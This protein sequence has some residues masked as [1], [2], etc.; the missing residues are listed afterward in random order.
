MNQDAEE[1]GHI[2][3]IRHLFLVL[4]A[5]LK[6]DFVCSSGNGSSGIDLFL[7]STRTAIRGIGAS[8]RKFSY[9]VFDGVTKKIAIDGQVAYC[10]GRTSE[11][12]IEC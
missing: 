6:S 10:I 7:T 4:G 3:Q 5:V 9:G 8:C 11:F 2:V 12:A 1:M